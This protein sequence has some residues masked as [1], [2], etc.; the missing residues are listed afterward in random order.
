MMRMNFMRG[1]LLNRVCPELRRGEAERDSHDEEEE[2]EAQH[3]L[4]EEGRVVDHGVHL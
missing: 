1:I 3:I 2:E 4:L